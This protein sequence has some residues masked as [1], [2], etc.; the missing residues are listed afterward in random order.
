MQYIES[1]IDKETEQVVLGSLLTE[2]TIIPEI[3]EIL[4]DD[5]DAFFTTDH[6]LIYTSIL[7]TFRNLSD[8]DP[9]L[10]GNTLNRNKQLHRV[11]GIEYLYDLQAPIVETESTPLYAE[12]LVE[13]L[14]RRQLIQTSAK[15]REYAVDESINVDTS[16][17]QSQEALYKIGK[18][19]DNNGYIDLGSALWDNARSIEESKGKSGIT[20]LRT[21]FID[22]D[23]LTG[24]LQP[25][26]LIIIAA[27]TSMGKTSFVL[28]IARNVSVNYE[29]PV[30]FF[31]LEMPVNN[32]SMRILSSETKIEFNRLRN[33]KFPDDLWEQIGDC[34]SKIADAPLKF[35]YTPG[36]TCQGLRTEARKLKMEEPDLSL[37]VVDYMQKMRVQNNSK[38]IREQEIAEISR[39]LSE[40]AGELNIPIITCSQ[41]NREIESRQNKQ[42]KL[43]DLRESGSIEQDADIVAF[44][45][46][47]DYYDDDDNLDEKV[48]S[49]LMIKKHRNGRHGTIML[50]FN[51]QLMLFE[52][53]L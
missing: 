2:K 15:I 9:I 48:E 45:H 40:I 41:L 24:G 39:T 37:I 6:K 29:K 32:L 21:G 38:M 22:F 26:Q 5:G 16:I 43:S 23:E 42:P 31:T 12:I 18:V 50:H 7:E 28:N 4:G 25:G 27:R 36:M 11:G 3:Q 44:L 53:V 19:Q 13:K 35:K 52:S 14:T 8:A 49:S 1:L 30:V 46:R 51:R 10:V 47:D 33:Y 34:V 17:L 20:G